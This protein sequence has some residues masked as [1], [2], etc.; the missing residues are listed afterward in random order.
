MQ[1]SRMIEQ[2]TLRDQKK[3]QVKRDVD[4]EIAF[5]EKEGGERE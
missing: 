3:D 5:V 2:M 4:R 1:R